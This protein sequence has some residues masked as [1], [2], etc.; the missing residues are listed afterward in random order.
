MKCQKCFKYGHN[1][2][3]CKVVPVDGTT[4]ASTQPKGKRGR[5]RKKGN[6]RA[7]PKAPRLAPRNA[8]PRLR[9]PN[10]KVDP[11]VANEFR[12]RFLKNKIDDLSTQNPYNLKSTVKKAEGDQEV[13]IEFVPLRGIEFE[14]KLEQ[15]LEEEVEIMANDQREVA[16]QRQMA[17]K[18]Y[19]CPIIAGGAMLERTAN[20]VYDIF[21]M[22]MP[23]YAKFF[24]E[25][26]S[27]K[28]RYG[29]N[30]KVMVSETASVVIQQQLPP[31]MKDP[32]S[33]TVDITMGDKKVAKAIIDLGA[34]INL[35]PYSTYAQLGLGELKPTTMSLQLADRSIKYPRGIMEDLLLQVG[36]LIFLADFVVLDMEGTSAKDKEQTIL[37]GRLFM[38]T[39][40]TVIDVHNGKLTMTVL[41]ETDKNDKLEVVLTLEKHEECLDEEVLDLHDKLDEAISVLPNESIIEPLDSPIERYYQV[42]IAPED[43]ART[44]FTCPFGTFAFRR[45]PFWLCNTPTTFQRFMLSIFSDM[46]ED[47]IEV[48]M[49]DFSVFGSSFDACLG[50]LTRMLER[51]IECNLTLS[52]EK[53]HFM[54]K[55]GIV[56]GHVVSS[57]DHAALRYLLTKP[58]A[59]LR[60]I[61]CQRSGNIS[62]RTETPQTFNLVVELFNVWGIDFMRP[63]SP[64][65]GYEYILVIVDYVSKWVEAIATQTNDAKIVCKFIKDNI[66]SKFGISRAFISNGETHFCNKAFSVLLKKYGVTHRVATPYHPQTSRQVEV[67]NRQIKS[68]LKKLVHPSR[69]D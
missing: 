55:Q 64:S 9:K 22:N 58:N 29:K 48:F 26:N 46:L 32:V 45:M 5:P 23:A 43:Q 14:E 51:C 2:R 69:K 34:S 54:V 42:S 49:D 61:R 16:A 38:A 4:G 40:E 8:Q 17:M 30:E 31:K 20:E 41:G 12:E 60:L 6:T 52:W 19:A 25:L 57:K 1:K 13:E 3:S 35:M 7:Q 27:N 37:L 33:F 24:K 62:K 47:C 65:H 59:K 21:K 56:L 44:T 63:F 15:K 66:F 53:S 39:T 11:Q 68:I 28:K 50:N 10:K 18:D 67:S 36:K